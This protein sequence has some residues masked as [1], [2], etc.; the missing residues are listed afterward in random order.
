MK[1]IDYLKPERVVMLS[2]T[3]KADAL[4]ELVDVLVKTGVGVEAGKINSREGISDYESLD[5]TPIHIIVLIAA[6]QGQHEAYIRL[7]GLVAD[8]LKKQALRQAIVAAE[9][10]S[11]ILRIFTEDGE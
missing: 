10:A 7:L 6:P 8:V 9:D 1:L 5:E 11:E 4:D 2:G 3:S